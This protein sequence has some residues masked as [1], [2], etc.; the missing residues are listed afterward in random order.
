M[1]GKIK[2]I[3]SIILIILVIVIIGIVIKNLINI[4]NDKEKEI[5]A[6]EK[7]NNIKNI[8]TY[9]NP[10]VPEGF[11]KVETDTAS[12]EEVNG[13]P[14]GWDKGLV[15]K[16]NIGNEF[17]W[18]PFKENINLKEYTLIGDFIFQDNGKGYSI[19]EF[20]QLLKPRI[21][22]FKI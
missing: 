19:K 2:E 18:V 22:C 13:K 21:L 20:I 10:I 6:E 14:K 3:I 17:V 5:P 9:D 7:Y 1:K 8:S 12:W 4:A 15:I 16:D 11:T